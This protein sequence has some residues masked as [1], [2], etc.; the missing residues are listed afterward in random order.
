MSS[1]AANAGVVRD[2]YSPIAADYEEIWA[3]RLL[4]Y[5]LMLLDR[6]PLGGARRV[7]EL[8]CGVGRLLPEIARRAPAAHVVGADLVEAMLR[9]ASP[10][11]GRVVIDGTRP[12][13][14]DGA[15]DAVVSAFCIFHFPDPTEAL[16]G[17]R[18]AVAPGGGVAV[19]VW[20]TGEV[21][22]AQDAWNEELDALGVPPDPAASG[23]GDGR[24][25][26]DSPEKLANAFR[27]AGFTDVAAESLGWRLEWD[28]EGF[29]A[30][31]TRMGPGRRRL[32]QL[33]EDRRREAVDRALARVEAM[34][35]EAL[36][37]TDE[38]VIGKGS[39]P[40]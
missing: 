13:F 9:R 32:I 29:L 3:P 16:A 14:V 6:V 5:G 19:A 25:Q 10:S 37:H 33:D 40:A 1:G 8:G 7:L 17:L 38:V 24:E 34:G 27:T 2:S 12:G 20:G 26:I 35:P 31:R 4:P 15:F 11:F 22:P 30:W 28:M 21:F 36:V 18:P 39:A 23:P